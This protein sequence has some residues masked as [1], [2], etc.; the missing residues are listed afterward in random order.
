MAPPVTGQ[1]PMKHQCWIMPTSSPFQVMTGITH[2][3]KQAKYVVTLVPMSTSMYTGEPDTSPKQI[4]RNEYVKYRKQTSLGQEVDL[5][6]LADGILLQ[7]YSGF[8]AAL[9]DA[10][11]PSK[12]CTCD[13]VPAADYPNVLDST[14]DAGGLL[15]SAWQTYWNISGNFFPSTFPVRCQACGKNVILPDGTRGD[16]PC[17]SDDE[18]W[19]VPSTK[20][21]TDGANPKEVVLDHNSK[22]EAYVQKKQDVPRWWVKD[23]TV[24]SKCPRGID[25]PDW[26]YKGEAAYSRQIYLLK[27][28]SKVVDLEKIAIGFETLGIDVQVQMESWEDPALP[29]TT[30]PLKAHKPP[31]PYNNYTYY[32]PCTQNMTLDNYH[33]KKRCAMPLLSQQWGP[34]FDADE[35]VGLENAVK[36]QLG[37]QLA[38]VG[39]FTLDG[40]LS[41]QKGS[42]RRYWHGELQKLN[43]TY[44]LPCVGDCCG[45]SGD[46]PFKPTPAPLVAHGSYTVK[47][48]DSCWNI[49]D[50]LCQD[51]NDWKTVICNGAAAC[52]A[53]QPGQVLNYDCSGKGTYCSGPTE[54]PTQIIV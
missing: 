43:Q 51:G 24:N 35:V 34:K 29:W 20:R 15:S 13:N 50:N 4:M 40:V 25:C 45:C 38:G 18:Q 6:D 30:S 19:F 33:E 44:G 54:A 53:L 2:A 37:K 41:Q 7:W 17:A 48:G 11:W 23:Q 16:M 32:K 14:R 46:D 1:P 5:L 9:C 26:R 10:T 3:M 52:S 39:F 22:L 21:S 49:A 28:L 27:S 8:D 31:T 36:Q 12:S 42:A 47:S